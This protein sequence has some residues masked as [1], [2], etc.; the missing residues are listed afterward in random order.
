MIRYLDPAL[1]AAYEAGHACGQH[2]PDIV[3]CHFR[4]FKTPDLLHAWEIGKRTSEQEL[5]KGRRP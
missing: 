3:N 5:A 1:Q 4:F 2:G